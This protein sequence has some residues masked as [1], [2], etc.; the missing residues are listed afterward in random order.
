MATTW[1]YNSKTVQCD[2]S[3]NFL[4]IFSFSTP[5]I[6]CVIIF[7][8]FVNLEMHSFNNT[9]SYYFLNWI[10]RNGCTFVHNNSPS[11]IF[12]SPRIWV[13]V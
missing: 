7:D 9:K 4:V 13:Q 10:T 5:K 8:R 1:G 3:S 6:E 12:M 11:Q 2:L